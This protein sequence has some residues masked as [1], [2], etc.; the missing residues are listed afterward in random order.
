VGERGESGAGSDAVLTG[1]AAVVTGGSRGIGRGVVERLARDG[2]IVV[3]GYRE[4]ADAAR[5]VERTVAEAGGEAHGV[6]SDLAESDG[7]ARLFA[8]AED[9]LDGLDILVNNAAA[10]SYLVPL[11]DITD[12][13]Y[14]RVFAVNTRAVFH[15][16]RHAARVMRDDGR[17]ITLST[18]NTIMQPPGGSL[19][20]GSKGAVEQFTVVAARELG[21]RGITANTVSPGATDTDLLRSSNP[22]E[23]LELMVTRTPMGR[24]GL[25]SDIADIVAFLASPDARWLTGQNLFATGGIR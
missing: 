13:E 10:N 11:Q 17:I 22:P 14:D 19:Y 5:D 23:A 24:L 21:K 7:V 12:A 6:R 16:M 2:A 25:P 15:A 1:R 3:F 4:D 18:L 8:A 20:C 9:Y